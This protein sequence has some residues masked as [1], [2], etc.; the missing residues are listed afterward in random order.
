MTAWPGPSQASVVY[1]S[2][3][4]IRFRGESCQGF[5]TIPQILDVTDGLVQNEQAC[6]EERDDAGPGV[7]PRPVEV[8]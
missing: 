6:T 4:S 7:D 8:D 1:D 5:V 2:R 3:T